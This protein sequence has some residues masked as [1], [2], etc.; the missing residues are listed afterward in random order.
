MHAQD[1]TFSSLQ[2]KDPDALLTLPEFIRESVPRTLQRAS[3]PNAVLT[4]NEA[5]RE[6]PNPP[7]TPGLSSVRSK[8]PKGTR[9][10][11]MS[12]PPLRWLLPASSKVLSA[13]RSIKGTSS[14][15]SSSAGK[16]GAF[17]PPFMHP[18]NLT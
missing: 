3:H 14:R 9:N 4:L 1:A 15:R 6:I 18:C 7:L 2:P 8:S 13:D 17:L 10:R 5:A 16:N 12:A 11:S